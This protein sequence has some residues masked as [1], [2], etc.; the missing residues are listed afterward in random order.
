MSALNIGSLLEHLA[1]KRPLF[2]SEADFQF[3]L[4]WQIRSAYDVEVRLETHPRPLVTLDAH[5]TG[6]TDGTRPLS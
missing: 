6:P 1:A 2:H 5:S 3:A 4:A